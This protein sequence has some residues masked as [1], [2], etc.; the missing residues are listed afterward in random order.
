MHSYEFTDDHG[1][2]WQRVNKRRARRA[3]EQGERLVLCACNMRPFGP[4]HPE[5]EVFPSEHNDWSSFDALVNSF[6]YYNCSHPGEGAYASYYM[7]K[8]V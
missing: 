8:E 2:R 3:Y 4:W 7:P 1:Q 6:E 5:Y